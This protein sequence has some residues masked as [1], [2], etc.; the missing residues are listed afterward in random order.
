MTICMS[1]ALK[2]DCEVILE[3]IDMTSNHHSLEAYTYKPLSLEHLELFESR[4]SNSCQSGG[5]NH[6][7]VKSSFDL[8]GSLARAR[9]SVFLWLLDV[10]RG[11]TIRKKPQQR[12]SYR[13]THISHERSSDAEDAYLVS[14]IASSHET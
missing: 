1:Y 8:V 14:C 12:R 2:S 10:Y 9:T 7:R 3:G 11:H 5:I 13:T 4:V 6:Y